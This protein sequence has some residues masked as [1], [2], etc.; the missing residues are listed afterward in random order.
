MDNSTSDFV[1]Q[2]VPI[3]LWWVIVA[4]PVY[5]VAKRKGVSGGWIALGMFPLW[6]VI[7]AWWWASL[8]DKEVLDRLSRLEGR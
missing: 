4:I 5:K 2:L 7:A 8:T 6:I 3:L 1:I